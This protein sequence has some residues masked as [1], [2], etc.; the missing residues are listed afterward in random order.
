ML[1]VLR[2]CDAVADELGK[3]GDGRQR[4]AQLVGDV[5][6][7]FAAELLAVLARRHVQQHEHRAR[8]AAVLH[9]RVGHELVDAAVER[10]GAQVVLAR[11][12][13]LHGLPEVL[14]AV[15]GQH[16]LLF[17]IFDL[18]QAARARIAEQQ[19]RPGVDDEQAFVHVLRDGGELR[20][21]AAQLVHLRGDLPVLGGNF[22][23]QGGKLVI[24]LR[25]LR[26]LQVEG[27]Q[28]ADDALRQTIGQQPRQRNGDKH[29]RNGRAQHAQQDA[30]HGITRSGQP[31]HRAVLQAAGIVERLLGQRRGI[32]LA[33]T[34]AVAQGVSHLGA[35]G[36]VLH[37]RGGSFVVI[38]DGA[39]GADPGDADR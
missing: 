35:R 31:E 7:E 38:A 22:L 20:L 26:M 25:L 18:Q 8:K 14:A 23:Q 2:L 10:Q 32:A 36:M 39:V 30:E 17:D 21:A 9:S 4:R 3:A 33:L 29:G 37:L 13:A 11:Q 12:S 28:R 24:G 27:I 19:V 16:G 6:R 5:R 15:H 1:H 34:R